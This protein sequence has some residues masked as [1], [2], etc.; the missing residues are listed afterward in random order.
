MNKMISDQNKLYMYM[1]LC[2]CL[3]IYIYMC[4]CV[5]ECVRQKKKTDKYMHNTDIHATCMN[6]R[7]SMS[8]I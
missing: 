3:Y 1:Y 2:V 7:N 4:V 8:F 6:W 5:F